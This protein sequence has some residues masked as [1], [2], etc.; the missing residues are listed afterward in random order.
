MPGAQP[1]FKSHP[2]LST[3]HT[4]MHAHIC[5]HTCTHVHTCTHM[6]SHTLMPMQACLYSYAS[7]GAH[8]HPHTLT[9]MHTRFHSHTHVSRHPLT[10]QQS[11]SQAERTAKASPH[12]VALFP[13]QEDTACLQTAWTSL[14]PQP[15]LQPE[16]IIGRASHTAEEDRRE[17]ERRTFGSDS[18]GTGL[19][20]A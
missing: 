20:P 15:V 8:T 18:S 16:G 7:T 17:P 1:L 6:P 11:P 19:A 3:T 14:S 9:Y 5:T 12:S 13:K 2:P 4:H 10:P